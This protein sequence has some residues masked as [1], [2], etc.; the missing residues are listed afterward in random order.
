M[1]N[2][3]AELPT[4]RLPRADEAPDELAKLKKELLSAE[5]RLAKARATVTCAEVDIRVLNSRLKA[6]VR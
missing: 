3:S 1:H 4:S 6:I 5:V 2:G